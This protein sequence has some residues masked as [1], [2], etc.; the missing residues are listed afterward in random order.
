MVKK[1]VYLSKHSR[2]SNKQIGTLLPHLSQKTRSKS[3]KSD[4]AVASYG[5]RSR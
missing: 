5:L 3:A 2:G 1:G 4:F